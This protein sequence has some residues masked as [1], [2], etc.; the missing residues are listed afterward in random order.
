MKKAQTQSV[1][2]G[3]VIALL[4]LALFFGLYLTLSGKLGG[5]VDT[6]RGFVRKP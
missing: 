2:I 3:V 1:I 6:L 5:V 4:V